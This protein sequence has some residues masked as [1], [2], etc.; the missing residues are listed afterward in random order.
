M[1]HVYR[2]LA[3]HVQGLRNNK[4]KIQKLWLSRDS[5][6]DHYLFGLEILPAT[7]G[8]PDEKIRLI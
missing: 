7:S 8:V 5:N 6:L 4:F 1:L 3:R 2:T